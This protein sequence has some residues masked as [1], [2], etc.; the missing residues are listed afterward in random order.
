MKYFILLISICLVSS[1]EFFLARR[2]KRLG[3]KTLQET[4][5]KNSLFV[6]GTIP[7]ELVPIF[8]GFRI[9]FLL[10]FWGCTIGVFIID[11]SEGI[12]KQDLLFTIGLPFLAVILTFHSKIMI[13]IFHN[14]GIYF[15]QDRLVVFKFSKQESLYSEIL[16]AVYK[17]PFAVSFGFLKIPVVSGRC[18]KIPVADL[19]KEPQKYQRLRS[20]LFEKYS[21]ELPEL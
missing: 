6:F 13:K 4:Y 10:L 19:K 2:R 14:A 1:V 12:L 11:A 18:L 7:Q 16:Q 3:L 5:K 8:S 9:L 21:I 17:K 15:M 20:L